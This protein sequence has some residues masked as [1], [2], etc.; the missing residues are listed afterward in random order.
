MKLM[1]LGAA[2]EVTG[3]CSM[4]SVNGKNIL[5]DCGLEQ[6]PDIFENCEAPVSPYEIHAVV[7][8]H[9]HIDHSGKI[10]FLVK[11]GM[12]SEIHTTVETQNLC[13]IMLKDSAHIQEFEA[14]W[15][16]R[17]AKRS[18]LSEY[19]PLYTMA[20]VERTLPLFRGHLYGEEI[21]LFDGVTITFFD[22]GHLLGS[23][24]VL[25][26]ITE[27][28]VKKSILFSGDLGNPPRPLIKPTDIPPKADYVVVE[29]TYGDRIHGEREDSLTRLTNII[30][31]TLDRGGNVV[32]PSFAVGRTQELLYML[33]V[34]KEQGLIKNHPN[35]PVYL[36]SPLSVEATS[37]YRSA[38]REFLN[39]D[40]IQLLD[41]GVNPISFPNLKF[42][43][44]DVESKA[45]NGDKTP[46]IIISASGMCE[47]GRIRH[48]LKHNLWKKE[49]T[50]LFVGYQTYGTLGRR[51]LDGADKVRLFGE[52]IAVNAKI[53]RIE[54]TSSHAD[55]NMLIDWLKEVGAKKI[56]V[57]H[58]ENRV[59]DR[60]SEEVVNRLKVPTV[61]PF[62]GDVFDLADG[63]YLKKAVVKEVSKK[64]TAHKRARAVYDDLLNAGHNLIHIIEQNRGGT[65]KELARFS[66][67]IKALCEKYK[68]K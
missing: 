23:S 39:D 65:N 7:L 38:N 10:P 9:A 16:N 17:K 24:S 42:T 2:H 35:F 8:T 62:P 47:A 67:Q 37:I 54:G 52:D 33:R 56:F 4:L 50:V 48:H 18:G 1:F 29:S 3:S 32:I 59:C 14:K 34:I 28:G 55:K 43:K 64:I 30:Q 13:E 44:T 26:K 25:F 5:I 60:F 11:N 41:K 49:N 31:S 58:G 68:R 40:A 45:I 12:T 61:P 19:Q 46:K 6:G 20:D 51:L 27:N 22:A 53:E 21:K 63:S 15:R 36:D 57:N 66:A